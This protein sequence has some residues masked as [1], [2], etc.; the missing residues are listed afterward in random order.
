MENFILPTIVSLIVGLVLL[1]L[2]HK[3][4][5][6]ERQLKKSTTD[7]IF[8]EIKTNQ[9]DINSSIA[10]WVIGTIIVTA[11]VTTIIV[12]QY[13][14]R[15]LN[16]ANTKLQN[17]E[18]SREWQLPETLKALGEASK[19][20][21][22]SLDERNQFEEQ[23]NKLQETEQKVTELKAENKTLQVENNSL[24]VLILPVDGFEFELGV[25]ETKALF[26]NSTY[27]GITSL[28]GITVLANIDNHPHVIDVGEYVDVSDDSRTIE[29]KLFLLSVQDSRAKF[30]FRCQ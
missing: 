5:W 27:I 10:K 9:W 24:K 1:F 17:Y 13:L 23:K 11:S 21:N 6:F 8:A 29:C 14:G 22:L 18:Q 2:E 20:F 16:F 30:S 25:G 28:V 7:Q 26:K 3:T 4:G 19:T 15:E 12:S